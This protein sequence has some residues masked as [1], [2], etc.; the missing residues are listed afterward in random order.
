MGSSQ[1]LRWI[2]ELNGITDADA[3][4][5][6]IK[7]EIRKLKKEPNK[8]INRKRIKELYEE[9]DSIQFKPDYMCLIID[10]IKDYHRACDGFYINGVKYIRLLGTAGGIKNSTIVFVS[11]RLHAEL[12]RRIDNGR[13]RNKEMVPAKFE[14]YKALACS[15]SIPVSLPNGILV[16][17]DMETT[18]IEDTIYLNDENDGE[19]EMEVRTNTE[20]TMDASDGF[21]LMLPSLA[22]RW[23]KE[24]GLDYMMSGCNTRFCWEKGMV[25]TFDFLD[26]ADNV[27]HQSTV[28][29]VWGNEVDIHSVELIFTES[30]L[31]LWDSY[32]SC[33]D[34]LRNC[35][36]NKY[37]IGIPKTCPKELENQRTLN[38]QF[39]QSY[40]LD[41]DD[42]EELISPTVN[43]IKDILGGDWRKTALFLLG[44]GLNDK[45][46]YNLP[47]TY[48]KAI[49]IDHNTVNDPFIKSNIYQLIRNR[50]NEAKVGVLNVHGN[51]S[52]ISGD[53]YS[54]CQN[55]FGLSVTGILKSGELY[56]KYWVDYGSDKVVCFRAPM[57]AHEN[58]RVAEVNRS[59]EA[60]YWYRYM[61]TC[62]ILNSFDCMT[63]A[64]NGADFDG[65]LMML[66]DNP[67]LLRKHI[68][69]PTIM[70][71][72]RKAKKMI[73]TEQDIIK[74]NIA[75]FG[76]EIGQVTNRV[77]S[78]YD[79]RT[80][81]K[82][83]SK[84][85]KELSYRIRCGQLIQQ[86]VI[87]KT[88]GI[89]AKPMPKTWY[90]R[91]AI[92]KLEDEKEREF[93]MSIV[94]DK[95]PY[96]MRYIYPEL[97]KQYNTYVQNANKNCMRLF[98]LE[99]DEMKQL[100]YDNLTDRQRT[101]LYY[102]N[103][104][105]PVGINDCVMNRICKRFEE[106]F[107]WFVKKH[108]K[109]SDFDYSIY[110]CD[111]EYSRSTFYE[112][113]KIYNDFNKRMQQYKIFA[114]YEKIDKDTQS[115]GFDMMKQQFRIECNEI[116][117]NVDSLQNI[118]LDICYRNSNS[119]RF[120]WSMC[121]N[122]I[123]ETLLNKNNRLIE[124]PCM[125]DD[126][127][128]VYCGNKFKVNRE[129]LIDIEL[130]NE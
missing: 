95:K 11:E 117:S 32:E 100:P 98:R 112:I 108:T 99:L 19:P 79:V 126:G 54:L 116:C 62:T 59:D 44:S 24:L 43:E 90:D 125:C 129:E 119:K 107:D 66:T 74:S 6:E 20:I 13:D 45:S 39:I 17:K 69:L 28:V 124:Y 121:G 47:N 127:D 101:F 73:P 87:D 51:Y 93:Y 85:Y 113:K 12:A 80:K 15:A 70:C 84:E 82:P 94:A 68:E 115:A 35:I 53:P 22:E 38:Y 61:N 9:L 86:N 26:F 76:N 27:A 48:F 23:S 18:F 102:Y 64:M 21:G 58:I 75:S 81:F 50:I 37:T 2:D 72:Q 1:V 97:M 5:V 41:D 10:K 96:F 4:A 91:H 46:A 65:D 7:S 34:Y 130:D 106:E 25:Y 77:T 40:D 88:K 92:G 123:I 33:D 89:V 103:L 8:S 104:K 31:K 110:K 29:D 16:V 52:M 78:M 105:I 109:N 71:V 49:L 14:A 83:E 55:I 42:I 3:K 122:N 67:V 118:L 60:K 63:A 120:V 114:S 128:V 56:N 57:S 111:S 36:E 30:M